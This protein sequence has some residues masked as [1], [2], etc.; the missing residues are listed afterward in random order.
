MPKSEI[1]SLPLT[2]ARRLLW[3]HKARESESGR[4]KRIVVALK[5]TAPTTGNLKLD[6]QSLA[7]GRIACVL[8]GF[9]SR[10]TIPASWCSSCSAHAT[11]CGHNYLSENGRPK[12][13]VV[14]QKW[15]CGHSNL[16]EQAKT[17]QATG[18]CL[19]TCQPIV[20]RC[21]NRQRLSPQQL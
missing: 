21:S 3:N 2:S 4:P 1:T 8:T 20:H 5:G 19:C 12:M 6:H 18:D 11:C 14:A 7:Q 15:P 9:R 16:S 17:S 10:T 13:R